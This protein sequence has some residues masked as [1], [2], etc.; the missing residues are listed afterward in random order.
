MRNHQDK[1]SDEILGHRGI[2]IRSVIIGLLFGLGLA[3][4]SIYAAYIAR[5]SWPTGPSS[6]NDTF[7]PEA[8]LL[9]VLFL[10]A[11]V[12]PILRRLSPGRTLSHSEILVILSMGLVGGVPTATLFGIIAIP[13]YLATPENQWQRYLHPYM[14]D[15]LVPTDEGMVITSLFKGLPEGYSGSWPWRAWVIP[16]FWWMLLLGAVAFVCAC[17]VVILRKQW[18]ENE[19]LSYP[20]LAPTLDLSMN[21]DSADAWPGLMQDRLFWIGV[22]PTFLL[23]LWNAVASLSPAFPSIPLG[24]KFYYFGRDFPPVYYYL[25]PY[26]VCF[27]YF[28]NLD[29][30]F[31]IWFFFLVFVVEFGVFN[32]LGYSIGGREDRGGS[33]DAGSSWQSFGAFCALVAWELWIARRHLKAA[34]SSIFRPGA[35]ESERQEM[36]PYRTAASGVVLGLIFVV[37][38]L[39][40]SGMDY[41]VAVPLVIAAFLL[42]A[43]VARIIAES[44]LLYVMGPMTAQ[45]F[46]ICLVGTRSVSAGALT[47]LSLSYVLSPTPPFGAPHPYLD[48][49]LP[50]LAHIAK[51]GDSIGGNRRRLFLA[52]ALAYVTTSVFALWLTLYW[53]YQVGAD[54]FGHA[55]VHSGVHLYP[56]TISKIKNP[57]DTDWNKIAFLGIGAVTMTAMMLVRHRVPGWPI[58]PI[59]FTISGTDLVRDHAVSIFIPWAI[60]SLLLRMG[61]IVLYRRF[62]ALFVGLLAGHVVGTLAAILVGLLQFWAMGSG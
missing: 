52:V 39:N 9:F 11:V 4:W 14:P 62:R 30:L 20:A 60:K 38:W 42:Y 13:H 55:F 29:T 33:Y 59:G 47:S 41:K 31:S 46:A 54:N 36:L 21:S 49:P 17:I 15:R 8:L 25:N 23:A 35:V 50:A 56:D 16:L 22:A 44:G 3:T 19:R 40:G 2:T 45:T 1:E 24:G 27:G 28:A 61:G 7:F 48:S 32:R 12:N 51:L 43:G 10:V 57:F 34:F 53:G 37:F 6:M 5:F 26:I 18:A 58:H